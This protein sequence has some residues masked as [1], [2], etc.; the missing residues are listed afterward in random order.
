ML[1]KD[2]PLMID[3]ENHRIQSSSSQNSDFPLFPVFAWMRNQSVRLFSR[4]EKKMFW[5]RVWKYIIV[6][7]CLIN[8]EI[9]LVITAF[10]YLF[11]P[12]MMDGLPAGAFA[13][14]ITFIIIKGL[15]GIEFIFYIH[16]LQKLQ[17]LRKIERICSLEMFDEIDLNNRLTFITGIL[18]YWNFLYDVYVL[19]CLRCTA[20]ECV[21]ATQDADNPVLGL[22]YTTIINFLFIVLFPIFYYLTLHIPCNCCQ[23]N[24]DKL[25]NKTDQV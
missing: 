11:L 1:F 23:K 22:F 21:H 12:T 18:I 15:S 20:T 6:Q 3:G 19:I 16:F 2:T 5:S 9:G 25:I 8:P 14:L 4:E 7:R 13:S 10:P 24:E 17:K